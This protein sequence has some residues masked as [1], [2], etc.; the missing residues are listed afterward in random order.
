MGLLL[1]EF[2]ISDLAQS[3]VLTLG[4]LGSLLLVIWQSRCECDMNCCYI[5]RCHRSPPPIDNKED[6]DEENDDV[7]INKKNI[8]EQIIPKDDP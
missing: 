3:V 7:E 5:W 6:E 1:E 8:T 4:A 2:T